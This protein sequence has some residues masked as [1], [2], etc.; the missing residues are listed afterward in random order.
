MSGFILFCTSADEAV[1]GNKGCRNPPSNWR[2]MRA[3][4]V[5]WPR[6]M[7]KRLKTIPVAWKI[8]AA[9]KNIHEC[10]GGT[11]QKDGYKAVSSIFPNSTP[12][13]LYFYSILAETGCLPIL[14]STTTSCSTSINFKT[15]WRKLVEQLSCQVFLPTTWSVPQQSLSGRMRSP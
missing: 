9:R 15:W 8:S 10:M 14:Y 11:V 12:K 13:V 7:I 5:T 4:E 3:G 2:S 1:K 6:H